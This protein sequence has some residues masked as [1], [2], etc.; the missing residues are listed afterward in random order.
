MF[1]FKKETSQG[2]WIS[3][4][5]EYLKVVREI[6]KS[7]FNARWIFLFACNRL[8]FAWRLK[9]VISLMINFNVSSITKF[10]KNRNNDNA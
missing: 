4:K 9:L 6:S 5:V 2:V 7:P 8:L 1:Y 3:L 10:S